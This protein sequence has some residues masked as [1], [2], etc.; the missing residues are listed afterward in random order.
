M[1][2]TLLPGA[3]GQRQQQEQ[4]PPHDENGPR[5]SETRHG[6]GELVVERDGV[7]AGQ[8]RQDGLVENQKRQQHQNTCSQTHA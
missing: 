6:P 7:V 8:Q 2:E 5:A 4:D 3:A 1:R